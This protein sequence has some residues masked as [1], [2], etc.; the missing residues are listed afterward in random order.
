MPSTLLSSILTGLDCERAVGR[1]KRPGISTASSERH[2]MAEPSASCQHRGDLNGCR[3]ALVRAWR[4]ERLADH[5]IMAG[6]REG[7]RQCREVLLK[8]LRNATSDDRS[9]R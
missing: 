2:H 4:E 3:L 6:L 9:R 5:C 7:C 8:G 1:G